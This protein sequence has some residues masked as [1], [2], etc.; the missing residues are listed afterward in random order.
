MAKIKKAKAKDSA[1]TPG[2]CVELFIMD[3]QVVSMS[4]LSDVVAH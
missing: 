1:S 4:L 3:D 2:F